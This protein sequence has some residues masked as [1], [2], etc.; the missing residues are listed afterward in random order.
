MATFLVFMGIALV[1][2]PTKVDYN[3]PAL[4]CLLA[5]IVFALLDII[6]KKYITRE[7]ILSMLFFSNLFASFCMFPVAWYYWQ[8]P[9]LAQLFILGILGVGSNLILYFLLKAF[10]LTD[11]SSL[12]PFRYTELVFSI[13]F[14]YLFF[15]EWPTFGTC[16]GAGI[17]ISSTC[18]IAY[19]QN[20]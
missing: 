8:V 1:F 4:A 6:N 15:Q 9:T 7:P 14:G 2:R 20:R 10:Q 18:F 19:Y 3:I 17:I 12:V 5:T 11:A 13:L 16:L